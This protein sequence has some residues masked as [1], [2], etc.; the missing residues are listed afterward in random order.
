[1]TEALRQLFDICEIQGVTIA[2]LLEDRIVTEEE[3]QQFGAQLGQ[4]VDDEARRN[5]IIDFGRVKFMSS[6][7]LGRLVQLK[8]RLR[9]VSGHL[10]L[11]CIDPTLLEVFR[12][13]RL[14]TVFEIHKDLQSALARS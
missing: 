7:A 3:I 11:C 5:I 2:T 14:D 4:L 6:A 9:A 1:M 8:K 13:T 12:I 10:K